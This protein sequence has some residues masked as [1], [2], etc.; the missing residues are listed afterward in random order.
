MNKDESLDRLLE[1]T[2]RTR[3]AT[4]PLD[5]CLDAE[6]LAAWS[7]GSLTPAERSAAEAHASD[8]DRCLSVLAAIARTSPPPLAPTKASWL[9]VRWLVPLTTAAVAITAWIVIQQPPAPRVSSPDNAVSDARKP[10]E[11]GQ[12]PREVAPQ[13]RTDALEKNAEAP[14]PAQE[15]ERDLSRRKAGAAAK[16][17]EV[18]ADRIAEGQ[19]RKPEAGSRKPDEGP[20]AARPAPAAPA[21]TPNAPSRAE[22][23]DERTQQLSAATALPVTIHSPDPAVRWRLVRSTVER[24]GDAGRTWTAQATGTSIDLLAGASPSVNVCWI[25]GRSGLVLVT[26]DGTTWRRLEFPETSVDLV[27][28]VARDGLEAT[29]TATNGRR[30][31]TTD[32]GRTWTLQE[33]PAA[34]F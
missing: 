8:C 27:G 13:S 25:V 3:D 16:P 28:V 2:S 17:S 12:G 22:L 24:S 29:V 14:P 18:A 10:D 9:S 23:K 20:G 33:N 5:A 6:T 11:R 31:R 30:Y 7:D 32:A 4:P 15:K 21:A 19:R 26:T 1:R 34:P